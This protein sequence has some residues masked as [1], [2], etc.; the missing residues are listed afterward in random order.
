MSNDVRNLLAEHIT[1]FATNL[2]ES[3]DE[4]EVHDELDRFLEFLCGALEAADRDGRR[5]VLYTSVN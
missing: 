4:Q 3:S 1:M 5:S 2:L